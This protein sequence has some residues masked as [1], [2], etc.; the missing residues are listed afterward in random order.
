[1]RKMLR[2]L[3]IGAIILF[4]AFIS[5]CKEGPAGPAGKDASEDALEGYAPGIKCETCHDA[6]T[7]TTYRVAAKELQYSVSMHGLGAVIWPKFK[8]CAGCHTNEG[9]N[10]RYLRGFANETFNINTPSG[11]ICY[12]NYPNSTPPGCFTCHAPHNRG[13]FTVRD[14]GAVN[15][16]TLVAG[17]TTQQWNSSSASNLCVKCHQPRMTSTPFTSSP[18]S[19]QPDPSKINITDTAK[20]YSSRWNNHV[21]G[22]PTQTL[23][24]FGGFNFQDTTFSNSYHTTLINIA[25]LG[26]EDCHM[27]KPNGANQNGGHTFAVRYLA[28]GSSSPSYNVNGCNVPGCHTSLTA[29]TSDAHWGKRAE[30][31]SKISQLANLMMD[32]NITKKWSL[33]QS[34]K[35]VPWLTLGTVGTI[36]GDS[37]WSVNASTSK[38]LVIVPAYKAGALWNL[39]QL[40]YEKSHGMHNYQYEIGLLNKSI[41]ELI[42]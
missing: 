17:Q 36:P 24:G 30:I 13:N 33:P 8:Y 18:V 22:E 23:L 15:I 20:I 31:I 14:S 26:C 10:E 38:P 1:M 21:S 7:D 42:K 34:G 41:W 32:T 25:G 12:Q 5:G 19:W 4:A 27:A 28:S 16:F 35:A 2:N 11:P 29:T 40:Q 37:T 9:F 6:A 39:Q 3:S